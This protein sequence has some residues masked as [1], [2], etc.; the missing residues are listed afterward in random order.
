MCWQPQPGSLALGSLHFWVLMLFPKP[1]CS[2]PDPEILVTCAASW[3]TFL[4]HPGSV[5][6]MIFSSRWGPP[7]NPNQVHSLQA[8]MWLDDQSPGKI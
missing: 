5:S 8:S 6:P 2:Q 4:P 1:L 7:L 3:V